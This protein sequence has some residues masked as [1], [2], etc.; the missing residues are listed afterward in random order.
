MWT[1]WLLLAAL[2]GCAL[3]A[4]EFGGRAKRFYDWEQKRAGPPAAL[5]ESGKIVKTSTKRILTFFRRSWCASGR[6][7]RGQAKVLCVQQAKVL[8]LSEEAGN[9]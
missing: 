3:G 8:R 9:G 5:I 2:V 4:A 7:T 1:S 6:D